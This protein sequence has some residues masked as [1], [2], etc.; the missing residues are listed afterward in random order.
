MPHARIRK[1]AILGLRFHILLSSSSFS[2]SFFFF[3]VL[4]V[5][6]RDIFIKRPK[7]GH[8]IKEI[9]ATILKQRS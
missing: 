3:F 6:I 1:N 5:F 7:L 9:V 2:F 4:A 8:S